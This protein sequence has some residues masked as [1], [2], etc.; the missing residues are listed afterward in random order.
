[1]KIEQYVVKG[2]I[3]TKNQAARLFEDFDYAF[4][5]ALS[6]ATVNEMAILTL[7]DGTEY[8]ILQR[9]RGRHAAQ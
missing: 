6:V 7:P 3:G 1:M 2:E 8:T 4:K 5:A 9:P